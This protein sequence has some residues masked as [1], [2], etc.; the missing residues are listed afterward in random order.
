MLTTKCLIFATSVLECNAE[1]RPGPHHRSGNWSHSNTFMSGLLPHQEE[2]W[3]RCRNDLQI[4]ERVSQPVGWRLWLCF[5]ALWQFLLIWCWL[6][7]GVPPA[8]EGRESRSPQRPEGQRE[9]IS[10]SGTQEDGAVWF[11]LSPQWTDLWR[12]ETGGGGL[13]QWGP[14]SP[15][16]HLHPG[17]RDQPTCPQVSHW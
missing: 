17:C 11:G 5:S 4:S 2:L 3:E 16:M 1:N 12:E 9:R 13:L 15:H 14:L 10:V 7:Q 8:Q 6:F